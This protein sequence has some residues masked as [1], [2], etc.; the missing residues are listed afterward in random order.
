MESDDFLDEAT[1]ATYNIL[2]LNYV[3]GSL[4]PLEML[5]IMKAIFQKKN[6]LYI[7]G[8]QIDNIDR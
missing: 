7:I 5:Q 4:Y 3:G 6:V 8:S 1:C 2:A